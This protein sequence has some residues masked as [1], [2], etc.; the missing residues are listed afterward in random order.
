MFNNPYNLP[1]LQCNPILSALP[2]K[3]GE[4]TESMYREH[5]YKQWK[6]QDERVK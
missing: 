3:Y 1:F 6:I 2:I 4:L 5:Q